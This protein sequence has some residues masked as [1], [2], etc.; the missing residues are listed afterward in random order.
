MGVI[1]GDVLEITVNHPTIGTKTWFP[2]SN[3]DSTLDPGGFRT[4][5][6]DNQ[7]D[8][9]GRMI[10]QMNRKRWSCELTISWDPRTSNEVDAVDAIS[11]SPEDATFTITHVSGAIYGGKGTIVGDVKGN[12]NTGELPIKLGGS[13]KLKKIVG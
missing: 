4:N 10:K 8:G 5:D 7:V 13:G 9:G 1:A 12:L 2:K 6:D 3:S 11:G